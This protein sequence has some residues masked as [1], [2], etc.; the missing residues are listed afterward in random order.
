MRH[1][2]VWSQQS[3]KLKRL[4][5]PTQFASQFSICLVEWNCA[6]YMASRI[7]NANLARALDCERSAARIALEPSKRISRVEI[8][9]GNQNGF[10]SLS[11]D[12]KSSCRSFMTILDRIS[13][14][15][16]VMVHIAKKSLSSQ[17][18]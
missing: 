9:G 2:A 15:M 7:E 3:S 6:L 18:E 13:S 12:D 17:Y 5:Q 10:Q 8:A 4:P 11:S 16:C 14:L 1:Q